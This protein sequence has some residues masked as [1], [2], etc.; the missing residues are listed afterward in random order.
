MM[1]KTGPGASHSQIASVLRQRIG[2]G[3]YPPGSP[4]PS[5]RELED[6]FGSSPTTV[7]RAIRTLKAEGLLEGVA[8]VGVFVRERRPVIHVSSSY[9]TQVGDQPR[10]TWRT[11]AERLGMRGTQ[12]L[13]HVGSVTAPE[14]ISNL[15][16]FEVGTTVAVRRRV[17][18]LDD[19]PVQLADS[20]YPLDIAQGTPLVEPRKLQGGTIATLERLGFTLGDFEEQVSAR[21]PTPDERQQL[22][23]AEGVPVM[24]L[25]RT[26]YTAD[27]RP[28]EVDHN[29]LA[30]DRHLLNYRLPVSG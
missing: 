24:V 16:R 7:Q 18:M 26:T 4:I 30:A 5:T 25:V 3:Q 22:R 17:M 1:T 14:E 29:V 15:F 21:M 27:E 9:V 13:A 11:E 10:A 20:Y 12:T 19:N 6:E 23:L 2:S 28:I 8:G